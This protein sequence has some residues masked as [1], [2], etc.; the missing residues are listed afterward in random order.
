M[1]VIIGSVHIA[2]HFYHSET[3]PKR[4]RANSSKEL[5]LELLTPYRF[6]YVYDLR[7]PLLSASNRQ[8]SHFTHP[9]VLQTVERSP[10]TW[11]KSSP[12]LPVLGMRLKHVHS[13]ML[14]SPLFPIL[15]APAPYFCSSEDSL[16]KL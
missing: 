1:I 4:D 16:Y 15:I 10:P 14:S 9:G 13:V 12:L 6:E 11:E 8:S 3:S 2:L 5:W 7:F